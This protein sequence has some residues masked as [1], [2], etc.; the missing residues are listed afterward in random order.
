MGDNWVSK[1]EN[2]DSRPLLGD[3]AIFR[4]YDPEG[5]CCSGVSKKLGLGRKPIT[6]EIEIHHPVEGSIKS[7]KKGLC[8]L[9]IRSSDRRSFFRE[10]SGS[11]W[12]NNPFKELI[13]LAL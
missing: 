10:C 5:G 11:I 7:V 2:W 4:F 13:Q 1:T 12:P 3:V 6:W 9:N 8:M